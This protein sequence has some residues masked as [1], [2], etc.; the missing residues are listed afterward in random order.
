[1][2]KV[3]NTTVRR[4]VI[5]LGSAKLATNGSINKL[6]PEEPNRTFDPPA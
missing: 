6:E 5:R 3:T 4:R 2:K 1:M